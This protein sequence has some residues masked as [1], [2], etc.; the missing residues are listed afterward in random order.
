VKALKLSPER[1]FTWKAGQFVTIR[2]E[3]LDLQADYTIITSPRQTDIWEVGVEAFPESKVGSILHGLEPG[4]EVAIRGPLGRFLLQPGDRPIMCIVKEIGITPII[5]FLW[6]MADEGNQR[7][8]KVL[9][10]QAPE[11]GRSF[12]EELKSLKERVKLHYERWAVKEGRILEGVFPVELRRKLTELKE[13]DYYIAG[14][15]DFVKRV[16]ETVMRSIPKER[17]FW[18]HFG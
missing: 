16:R 11:F 10:I 15:S 18:E 8:I 2:L 14:A 12:E 5:G 7:F 9:H 17:V 3:S 1:P 6:E 13:A 4:A